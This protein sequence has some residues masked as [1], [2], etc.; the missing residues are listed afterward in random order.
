MPI[1]RIDLR[2]YQESIAARLA[3]AQENAGPPAL[4]GFESGGECWLVDLPAA[5]EVLPVPAL[6]FVPLTQ[7]WFAGL[8]SAH[9]DLQPVVDFSVFRGGP[10]TPRAGVAR[11]LRIGA[12]HATRCA[13]LVDRV[14]G[15]RRTDVLKPESAA[16]PA[17]GWRGA[18]FIDDRGE[19]W[20]RLEPARLLADPVLLDAALPETVAAGG[21]P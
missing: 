5:G 9:G 13:L 18:T 11:I 3:A 12:R 4:L 14:H 20:I 7:P 2:A 15:L 16:L 10:P 17:A 1:E 21:T 6:S 8:A 19:R